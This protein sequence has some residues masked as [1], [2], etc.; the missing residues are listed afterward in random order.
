VN[1]ND[2]QTELY[3]SGFQYLQVETGGTARATRWINQSYQELCDLEN[4]PFLETTATGT[5]PLAITDLSMI[6]SVLDA[7]NKTKLEAVRWQDLT[8]SYPDLTT[9]GAP[10][11]YYLTAGTTVNTYP[12]AS[13]SLSVRYYKNPTDLANAGDTPIIP[14][15]F[16]DLIVLG[17]WRRAL[18]DDSGAGDYQFIQQEWTSRVNVMRASLLPDPERQVLTA[19]SQDAG[20]L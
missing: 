17:A 20:W 6:E 1:L 2:L 4:W 15:A 7:T 3:A 11:F 18:L 5:S 9:V 13:V 19:G 12:A 14:T 8:D 16:H 10:I